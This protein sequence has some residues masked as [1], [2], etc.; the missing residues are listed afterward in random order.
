MRQ[1]EFQIRKPDHIS[2]SQIRTYQRCPRLWYLQK[3]MGYDPP[4]TPAMAL[5]KCVHLAL[6][7]YTNMYMDNHIHSEEDMHLAWREAVKDIDEIKGLL[8]FQD[9]SLGA[10]WLSELL[11]SDLLYLDWTMNVEYEFRVEFDGVTVDGRIDRVDDM[12]GI[13][14]LVDYK[15]GF[16]IVDHDLVDTDLQLALYAAAWQDVTGIHTDDIRVAMLDV[17]TLTYAETVKTQ[18]ELDAIR[19]YAVDC[20]RRIKA[21]KEFEPTPGDSCTVYG[22]CWAASLCPAI[23]LNR[24]RTGDGEVDLAQFSNEELL[25]LYATVELIAPKIRAALRGK[26]SDTGTMEGDSNMAQLIAKTRSVASDEVFAEFLDMFIP[27]GLN[28]ANC[29]NV[30]KTKLEKERHKLAQAILAN[31]NLDWSTRQTLIR[32]M[33]MMLEAMFQEKATT[34]GISVAPKVNEDVAGRKTLEPD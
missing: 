14:R 25:R 11:K 9:Y 30:S 13:Y 6:A 34:P 5:G 26:A 19:D 7:N 3:M 31:E 18:E 10:S 29:C 17:R 24:I 21:D 28:V 33:E 32:D 8:S 27:Y 20:A 16:M 12:D 1:L 15:S 23:G 22:G 2:F 4:E